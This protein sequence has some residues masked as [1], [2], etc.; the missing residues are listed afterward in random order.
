MKTLRVIAVLAGKRIRT[1]LRVLAFHGVVLVAFL[2][3]YGCNRPVELRL[4]LK[5]GDVYTSLITVS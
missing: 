5:P 1:W 3:L 4:Q 2:G